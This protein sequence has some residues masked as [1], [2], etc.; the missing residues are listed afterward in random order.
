M[1]TFGVCSLIMLAFG[2]DFLTSVS[3]VAATLGGVGPGFSLVGPATT[4]S[5]LP[6]IAK[7][8]LCFCMLAGRLELFTLFVLFIPSYWKE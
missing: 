3:S 4:Y 6:G 7:I 2:N 1:V 8:V 5:Y